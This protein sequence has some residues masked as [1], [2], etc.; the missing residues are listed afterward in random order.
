M[1]GGRYKSRTVLGRTKRELERNWRQFLNELEFGIGREHG[2]VRVGDFAQAWLAQV[3]R[4]RSF[5]TWRRYRTVVHTYVVPTLGHFRLDRLTHADVQ[6]CVD[7]V[8]DQGKVATAETLRLVLHSMCKLAVRRRL[9]ITNP[10]VDI[11]LPPR[12]RRAYRVLSADEA[13]RLMDVCRLGSSRLRQLYPIVHLMLHTGL[14][15]GE[16]LG[17]RWDAV[18]FEHRTIHVREQLK[19]RRGGF[20]LGKTKTGD[21]RLVFAG[22]PVMAV[23]ERHKREQDALRAEL[24]P[25]Y[26]DRGFVFTRLDGRA[27]T[28]GAP[29]GPNT[30]SRWFVEA[31]R[32]AGLPALRVHDLRDTAATLA[33]AAGVD[34]V[35]VSEMLGHSSI[36]MTA[37]RYVHPHSTTKRDAAD[38]LAGAL[39]GNYEP[40][41]SRTRRIGA[42]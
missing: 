1:G 23:L 21:R 5:G 8:V 9:L 29:I 20:G 12:Q 31:L 14:R 2:R 4:S 30:L 34:L 22:E 40:S 25:A 17:L 10:V 38:R 41:M 18:D 39:A 13:L 37:D 42:V 7:L 6:H 33:I 16:A 24:G 26:V 15:R 36:T 11:A 32:V 3:E 27:R 35:T 28:H 19:R